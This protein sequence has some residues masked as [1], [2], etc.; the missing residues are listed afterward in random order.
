M[1]KIKQKCVTWN[2]NGKLR[3]ENN[4]TLKKLVFICNKCGR[5]YW[6]DY[7]IKGDKDEM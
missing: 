3:E 6:S 2:C 4:E 5:E 1:S 7:A